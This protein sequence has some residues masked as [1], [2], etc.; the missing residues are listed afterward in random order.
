MLPMKIRVTRLNSGGMPPTGAGPAGQ[1]AAALQV[2]A[3]AINCRAV[4]SM[5]VPAPAEST[6]PDWAEIGHEN[7]LMMLDPA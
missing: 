7:A 4:L 5:T 1:V 6:Q 2:H 3:P